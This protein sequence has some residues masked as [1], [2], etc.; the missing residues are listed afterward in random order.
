MKM[1]V[2]D[3]FQTEWYMERFT[4]DIYNMFAHSHIVSWQNL[5]KTSF[6]FTVFWSQSN[7]SVIG[8]LKTFSETPS[9]FEDVFKGKND[10][11]R[12]QAWAD[13]NDNAL[14]IV[15]VSELVDI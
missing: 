5:T 9:V 1:Y 12:L 4:V 6:G 2:L 10:W 7:E 11:H 15:R 3:P 13:V 8:Y 14:E